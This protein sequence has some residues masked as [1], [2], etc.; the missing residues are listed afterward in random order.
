MYRTAYPTDITDQMWDVIQVYIPNEKPGG[1]PRDTDIREVINGILYVLNSD[2][3]WRQMPDDLLPWQTVY[4]Y[5]NK[6]RKNGIWESLSLVFVEYNMLDMV[7]L[8]PMYA[9]V[10]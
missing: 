7:H 8:P 1:R 4:D 6:W 3:S 9:Q 2:C 5:Y 10:S